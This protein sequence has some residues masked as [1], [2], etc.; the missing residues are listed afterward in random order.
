[1]K[2]IVLIA[3]VCSICLT[4]AA[5]SGSSPDSTA[6]TADQ[7]TL[8]A[9]AQETTKEDADTTIRPKETPTE[10]QTE[11]QTEPVTEVVND[12][13]D[14]WKQLYIDFFNS[15]ESNGL[16][17]YG[18]TIADVDEDG[19][20]ELFCTPFAVA[21][22]QM[23]WIQNGEV[24]MQ[25]IG[26]G[27]VKYIPSQY[28]IYCNYV[29]HG[30]YQDYVYSFNNHELNTVFSGSILP[31]ENGFDNP[32]RFIGDS[33]ESV[34]EKEYNAALNEAFDMNSAQSINSGQQVEN[35]MLISA[36]ENY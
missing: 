2:K 6:T 26:Y 28:L 5:C 34:T 20:P 8:Q 15:S 30:M 4:T 10:I 22:T 9:T 29:N 23:T 19:I 36:I 7:T 33:Q 18:F 3:F 12:T 13:S 17:A 31:E 1:M 32:G 25:P 14:E 21:G 35:G 11:K 27:E 16:G 24:K